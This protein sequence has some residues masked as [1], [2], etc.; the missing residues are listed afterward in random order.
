MPPQSVCS[1]LVFSYFPILSKHTYCVLDFK[2]VIASLGQMPMGKGQSKN[3]LRNAPALSLLPPCQ[4]P[5][6]HGG[7][8]WKGRGWLKAMMPVKCRYAGSNGQVCKSELREGEHSN[9]SVLG[10]KDRFP[11][12]HKRNFTVPLRAALNT[13]Y[14]RCLKQGSDTKHVPAKDKT[15]KKLPSYQLFVT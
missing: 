10:I 1:P 7:T 3:A 14:G 11:Q 8:G 4:W 2:E 12:R 9:A 13:T 15:Q 5:G 6:L